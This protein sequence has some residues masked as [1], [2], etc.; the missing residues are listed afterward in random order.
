MSH[1]KITLC[2][3]ISDLS[4]GFD[5]VTGE[6]RRALNPWQLRR[7]FLT[8]PLEDWEG[9]GKR[10]GYLGVAKI[11]RD[12]FANWQRF[13]RKA[14]VLHRREWGTL[15]GEFDKQK[16]DTLRGPFAINLQWEGKTPVGVFYCMGAF[17][18]IGATIHLDALQEAEFRDC[19]RHDCKN[20]PFR[21]EARHKIFCSP[22]CAHLVAVRRSRER[23][24]EAKSKAAKRAANGKNR[25]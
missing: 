25:G 24:A 22:E 1:T 23:V 8:W 17:E 15:A 18:T 21:V 14:M 16:V 6:L 10:V 13:F 4:Y 12:E 3:A 5:D 11:S 2:V 9:F 19:A 20:P 7:D